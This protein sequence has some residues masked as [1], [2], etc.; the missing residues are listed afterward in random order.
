MNILNI[1][2]LI[3]PNT[4]R[5]YVYFDLPYPFEGN[6]KD[7]RMNMFFETPP[8]KAEEY[9]KKHFPGIEYKIKKIC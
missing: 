3:T 2:I 8:H 9:V 7:G 4:D 1:E 6:F 5:V